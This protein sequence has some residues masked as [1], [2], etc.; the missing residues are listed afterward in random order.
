MPRR[1][2][3]DS[4]VTLAWLFDEDKSTRRIEP[5]LAGSDLVAPWLWRLEVVNVIL[6]R[7]RRKLLTVARGT[8]LL[9]LLEDLD[10]EIVGE[11]PSRSLTALAAAARP[12][13]LTAYDAVYLDLAISHGLPLFTRDHNL[14]DA[15]NRLGLILVTMSLE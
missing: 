15:A 7:E 6:I 12:H 1:I 2:V 10:V 9:Q 4:S 11:P 5:V 8:Q 14:R 3:I 13:Q